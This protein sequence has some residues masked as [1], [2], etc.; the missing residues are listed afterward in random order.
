MEKIESP[1]SVLSVVQPPSSTPVDATKPSKIR[2]QTTAA[3][4]FPPLSARKA[5]TTP[6]MLIRPPQRSDFESWRSLRLQPQVMV[7]MN[8]GGPDT[9]EAESRAAFEQFFLPEVAASTYVWFGFDRTT[10]AF[11]GFAGV[12]H[13]QGPFFGW[14]QMTGAATVDAWGK[15][16]STEF[17]GAFLEMWWELPRRE[18]EIEVDACTLHLNVME[19]ENAA[20]GREGRVEEQLTTFTLVDNEAVHA[21][22]RRYGFEEFKRWDIF[23]ERKHSSTQGQNN[24]WT[25]W[26]AVPPKDDELSCASRPT[27]APSV[28]ESKVQ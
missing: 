8:E 25:A 23:D 3:Y 10:G 7:N 2:V 1:V 19:S 28:E 17:L 14:P 9:T 15:G 12:N 18:V 11:L 21:I 6:R 16:F 20:A 5:V 27:L 13:A 4:P 22:M 26:A 24:L